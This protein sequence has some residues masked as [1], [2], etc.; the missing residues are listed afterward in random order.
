M[1]EIANMDDSS[2]AILI[3]EDEEND[4]MLLKLAFKKNNIL[5][6]LHWVRDGLE[7][8]SPVCAGG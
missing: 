3:V 4:A 5:N 8:T 7:A 6:P 2:Y 1:K